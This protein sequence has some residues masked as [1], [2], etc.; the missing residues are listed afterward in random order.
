VW[1]AG[2]VLED[3]PSADFATLAGRAD[4]G[5]LVLL[6]VRR[7]PEWEVS[8]LRA[9][10]HIPLHELPARLS[11]IPAGEIWVHCEAGYRAAVAASLLAARGRQVVA[12][13]D[14][15][16]SAAEA[17]LPLGRERRGK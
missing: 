14:Q 2:Q 8:H 15:F 11:E 12:I 13:N 1:G 4:L 7:R 5:S 10:V 17:G 16:S 3:F 9:A 6:D